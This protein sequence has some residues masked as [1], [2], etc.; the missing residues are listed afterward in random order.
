MGVPLTAHN[1]FRQSG[2]PRGGTGESRSDRPQ[3]AHTE[4]MPQFARVPPHACH[5]RPARLISTSTLEPHVG[6]RE[7]TRTTTPPAGIKRRYPQGNDKP[8]HRLR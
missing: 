8:P 4:A 3:H 5:S 7:F 1:H 2:L 6:K